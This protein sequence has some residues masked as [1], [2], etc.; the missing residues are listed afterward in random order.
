MSPANCSKK[1][2]MSRTVCHRGRPTSGNTPKRERDGV[3][4]EWCGDY[5]CRRSHVAR[6]LLFVCFLVFAGSTIADDKTDKEKAQKLRKEIADLRAQLAAKEA[7]LA[8]LD[9]VK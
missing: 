4:F 3:S 1:S 5:T 2:F 8:K 6:S 7:E 9:P